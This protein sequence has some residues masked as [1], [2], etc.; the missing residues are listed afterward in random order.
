MKTSNVKIYS[1]G[2]NKG[3]LGYG[4]NWWFNP[5]ISNSFLIFNLNS[6][7]QNDYFKH[8]HVDYTVAKKYVDCILE[9]GGVLLGRNVLTI[10]EAGS[11][12]G[13]F[14]K[15]FIKRKINIFAIEGS[16]AGYEKTK[17]RVGR[18]HI[19]RVLQ[20]DLRLP[21]YL[22][23]QFD[24]AICTE[25]AEHIEPP[26]SSQ[27]IQTLTNHSKIIWFSFEKPLTNEQHYHHSNE[28]PEK[29]WRNLFQ[30]YDFN[31]IKLPKKLTEDIANRGGY[32]FYH[33]SLKTPKKIRQYVVLNHNS[34]ENSEEINSRPFIY[35]KT[36]TF[37]EKICQRIRAI[38]FYIARMLFRLSDKIGK[39][40]EKIHYPT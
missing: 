26:F 1:K 39:L 8:E 10:L 22:D 20:H 32:I 27:L 14:T 18:K 5:N 13:W 6:F 16:K 3:W 33:K 23:R 40:A 17:K 21:L 9:Y 19:S 11:G 12:G 36:S 25:V 35:K 7:Y 24:I 4:T 31:M 15:E 30:F 38:P 2:K 37:A 29:F 28:Q 34:F